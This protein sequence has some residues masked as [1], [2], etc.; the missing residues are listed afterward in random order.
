[1]IVPRGGPVPRHPSQ[2]YQAFFEG[3]LLFAL[4]QLVWRLTEGRRRPGLLTGVF[5]AGYALA[6]IVGE[7]FR[8]PDSFLGFL[9]G[10]LTMG[11]LL[12]VPM[13]LFGAVLIVRAYQQPVVAQ[14]KA[15]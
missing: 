3:V 1:M 15:S 9:W 5:C 8:E 7:I 4:V 6:R 13:L 14:P 2:L 11:M 12:S 10:P